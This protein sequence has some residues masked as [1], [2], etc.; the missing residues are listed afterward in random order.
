MRDS[1][2][3]TEVICRFCGERYVFPPEELVAMCAEREAELRAKKAQAPAPEET[4]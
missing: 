4:P 3:E 2:E 1:G